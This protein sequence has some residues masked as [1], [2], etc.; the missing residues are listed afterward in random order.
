MMGF[1]LSFI[2]VCVC[3]CTCMRARTCMRV[4]FNVLRTAH[5]SYDSVIPAHLYLF[6]LCCVCVCFHL[7]ISAGLSPFHEENVLQNVVH[8]WWIEVAVIRTYYSN[9]IQRRNNGPQGKTEGLMLQHVLPTRSQK[10]FV[11]TSVYCIFIFRTLLVYQN[12]NI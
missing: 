7:I 9:Q 1:L 10:N 5:K 8:I 11:P 3:V 12:C 6:I 4:C 2:S